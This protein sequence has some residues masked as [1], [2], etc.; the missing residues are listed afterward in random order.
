MEDE[1]NNNKPSDPID[2]SEYLQSLC[3]YIDENIW[4]KKKIEKQKKQKKPAIKKDGNGIPFIYKDVVRE[5][6]FPKWNKMSITEIEV[7]TM[8]GEKRKGERYIYI[9]FTTLDGKWSARH[10]ISQQ[11][12]K[13]KLHRELKMRRPGVKSAYLEKKLWVNLDVRFGE[14]F[15]KNKEFV[16]VKDF[17]GERPVN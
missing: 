12:E 11:Q 4:R 2:S 17:V 7:K 10:F 6:N 16:Y 3:N 13:E 8:K 5:K 9:V 14:G 1:L 15:Y